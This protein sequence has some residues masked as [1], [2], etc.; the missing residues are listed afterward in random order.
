MLLTLRRTFHPRHKKS[1]LK[2]ETTAKE[3]Y[4][5]I[6]GKHFVLCATQILKIRWY[7]SFICTQTHTH[8]HTQHSLQFLS[9]Q[10]F[11][12]QP[13]VI[14]LLAAL[15][16][17]TA[18][19]CVRLKCVITDCVLMNVAYKNFSDMCSK[20]LTGCI[21]HGISALVLTE[22]TFTVSVISTYHTVWKV[23][24]LFL[25]KQGKN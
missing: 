7:N 23:I 10:E 13:S 8:T 4:N 15:L 2:S 9:Q 25:K 11:V 14:Q 21:K 22:I 19:C 18:H 16:E 20:L 6:P 24:F 3:R 12:L 5:K 1:S 17:R